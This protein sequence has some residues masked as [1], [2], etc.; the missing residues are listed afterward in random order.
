MLPNKAKQTLAANLRL[1]SG[2]TDTQAFRER[3][4]KKT[5]GEVSARTIGS[6][7]SASAGNPTLANIEAVAAALNVTLRDLFTEGLGRTACNGEQTQQPR[8]LAAL[9]QLQARYAAADPATRTLVDL[10]L[11]DPD[12]PLPEGLSPSLRAMVNMARAAIR[13]ELNRK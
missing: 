5:G 4:A 12:Q 6:M 2:G 9:D 3:I 8:A 11:A 10:A 1:L 7:M 13:D